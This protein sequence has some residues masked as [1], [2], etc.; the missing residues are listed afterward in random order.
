MA[1]EMYE[2]EYKTEEYKDGEILLTDN[3]IKF[4]IPGRIEYDLDYEQII[5]VLRALNTL[6]KEELKK[7]PVIKGNNL[8]RFE[9]NVENDDYD[10]AIEDYYPIYQLEQGVGTIE[11]Y[12][13]TFIL[14]GKKENFKIDKDIPINVEIDSKLNKYFEDPEISEWYKI[15]LALLNK[16]ADEGEVIIYEEDCKFLLPLDIYFIFEENALNSY[17]L[18]I[19]PKENL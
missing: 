19:K 14:E 4:F 7:N 18:D 17:F 6:T 11:S 13:P 5:E 12:T 9:K 3:N 16:Y 8:F 10:Y 2:D 1:E 15:C